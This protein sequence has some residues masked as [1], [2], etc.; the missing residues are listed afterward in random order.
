[1]G[2][3][4]AATLCRTSAAFLYDVYSPELAL[5][6]YSTS[7]VDGA[8]V[9]DYR[10]QGAIRYTINTLLGLQQAGEAGLLPTGTSPP[11]ALVEAFLERRWH[12][13]RSPADLGL[14]L[15]LLRQSQR[16]DAV[17]GAVGELHA[18][19]ASG[20]H[21]TLHV[22]DLCW[23]LW[24][25]TAT[26]P[27]DDRAEHA[28]RAVYRTIVAERVDPNSSLPRHSLSRYRRGFVSFGAI[29]YFL[30]A[31]S[32]Y[33]ALTGEDHARSLFD[34]G[35]RTMMANQGPQGEWP[36]LF[37]VARA[38]PVEH[39]PVFAVH[40]DSMAM[41][42]LL[43]AFDCGLADSRTAMSR[44]F[45]WVLGRNELSAPMFTD[46]PFSAFRSVERTDRLPRATRY[47]RALGRSA[48]RRASRAGARRV[49][50]NPE[51]RSYHL[52][53]LLFVWSK[54]LQLLDE[55]VSVSVASLE[56]PEQPTPR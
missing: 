48:T 3:F 29:V 39:Y 23:M 10:L 34:Q 37:S 5:F 13:V 33:A 18:I 51:C 28:A 15:V 32:E 54:R 55:V 14:A 4:S 27:D 56:A 52:G 45:A 19:V 30:R 50:I 26:A 21:T 53:W 24:G 25:L 16:G 11:A 20:A 22:Q 49:R 9:N 1:M 35:V 17:G 31:M 36:W 41:L 2:E 7:V 44:S 38:V 43:P 8:Y 46:E 40:Q 12:D 47:A 6:P 42:F